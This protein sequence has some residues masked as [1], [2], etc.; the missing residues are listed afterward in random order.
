MQGPGFRVQGSEFGSQGLGLRVQ[1]SGCGERESEIAR[2]RERARE[3]ERWREGERGR[4]G[5]RERGREGRRG[6]HLFEHFGLVDVREVRVR[7]LPRAFVFS[8]ATLRSPI[9]RL[10][11]LR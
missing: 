6:G 3:R 2:A 8:I 1:G 9:S 4:E 7:A 10:I 11:S 5:E